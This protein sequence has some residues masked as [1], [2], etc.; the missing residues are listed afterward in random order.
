MGL[1]FAVIP[2]SLYWALWNFSY[3]AP[4]RGAVGD[5]AVVNTGLR[6]TKWLCC[7]PRGYRFRWRVS[8]THPQ[9]KRQAHRGGREQYDT[10]DLP[11][12]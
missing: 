9:L 5:T 3:L 6:K 10:T 2:G 4:S 11:G 12:K 1:G 7:A 8:R